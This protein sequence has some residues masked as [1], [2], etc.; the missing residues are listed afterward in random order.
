MWIKF[1]LGGEVSKNFAECVLVSWITA[2]WKP[3]FTQGRDWITIYTFWHIYSEL[4]DI[5]CQGPEHYAVQLRESWH[6]V[7]RRPN[8][9]YVHKFSYIHPRT[10]N[11][12]DNQKIKNAPVNSVHNTSRSAPL[13]ILYIRLSFLLIFCVSVSVS[14]HHFLLSIREV[15]TFCL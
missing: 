12:Y 14:V 10:A 15:L 6:S 5:R 4:V 9:S 8:F 3:F 2:Q 1:V 13:A 11:P 7:L